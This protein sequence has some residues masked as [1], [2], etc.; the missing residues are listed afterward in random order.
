MKQVVHC[1]I[2]V[3]GLVWC[4]GAA[5]QDFAGQNVTAVRFSGLQRVSEQLVRSQVEVQPGTA[6]DSR[7]IARDIRRLY[8]MGYFAFI[9]ADAA[10]EGGGVAI[11]YV[12]EEKR[13]IE[14]I[15][16]IGNDSIRTRTVRG[17]LS[18]QEGDSF[19]A[20]A[21]DDER[22]AVLELYQ[23]KG[24]PNASVD[25][26]VE[27]AGPSRVR[28]TY[29][30]DEGDKAR[31]KSVEFEG[32]DVL[33]DRKLR[34]LIK[35]KR[36]WWFLGGKYDEE[37]FETDLANI[38]NEYGNYGRLEAAIAGT[39]FDFEDDGK[40]VD[41]RIQI[42]EG[43][44]YTVETLEVQNNAVFDDDEILEV[45]RVE[46]GDVHNRDQVQKDADTI[47]NGYSDSGYIEAQVDPLVTLDRDKKTT[48]IAH[49]VN[50]GDLKYVKEIDI[51]GNSGTKD[52]VVRNQVLLE[53]GD[54]FDG[55]LLELSQRQ[56]ENTGYY[57]TVRFMQEADPLDER[58]ANVLI[59]VEESKT[60]EL[61]FGAGYSTEEQLS[62]FFELRRSNFDIMNWP[63]FTGAGQQFRLRLQLGDV[64][65]N[66]SVSFTDPDIFGYPLAF[67]FDVYDE[68][69]RYHGGTSY[70]E[71]TQGAQLRLGKV[72]SPFVTARTA[73]RYSEID[74]SNIPA[75]ASRD[76]RRQR[77]GSTTIGN[78]WG[79][80]RNTLDN[81]RDPTSGSQHDLELELAG[82]GGD[83]HFYRA[84]HDSSWYRPVGEEERWVLSYRTR[85]GW[86]NEYGS[87]DFVP[88]S[89]RYF[90]GGTSTVRG[91]DTRDIGPEER[92]FFLFG[93]KE[94]VGGELRLVN[95][96]EVKYK[97]TDQV[98]LY[99][100]VDAGG[101]WSETS[102]F[103]LSD[104]RYG[105]G[106]GFGVNIPRLGPI[107]VDV[108]Y[109]LNPDDSQSSSPRVHLLTGF[110]F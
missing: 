43:P 107:R 29:T 99:S 69:Y 58:F 64:R 1:L 18:W 72:L 25:I 38:V 89:F 70:T 91:Y 7:A 14:E 102:D 30:I 56:L 55:T 83:N 79:I 32:N 40:G 95:N 85:Q 66:Y 39:E 100:F 93:E 51:T 77:G 96:L 4:L 27:D 65:T 5:A 33:S 37:Q 34:R 44:E 52:E 10:P 23:T 78:L 16:I 61:S 75:F 101:V 68:R 49:R 67:G 22:Q 82:L 106:L 15:R 48:H 84:E 88:I 103:D 21:Y 86:I 104:M 50:E 26:A 9:R 98:R 54:R 41:I 81:P 71:D 109:P 87:S 53:P 73:L 2:G 31:V 59:D 12:V 36:A 28:I 35:T 92:R 110:R 80:N 13:V 17:A 62:G 76:L 42:A 63:T 45:I 6:Y 47:R 60:G 24:F 19:V 97:L 105:A 57:E 94:R 74:V 20:S 108:G 8:D 90:A 46:A 11:T 3:V